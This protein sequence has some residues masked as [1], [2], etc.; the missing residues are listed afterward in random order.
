MSTLVERGSVVVGIDGSSHSELALAWAVHQAETERRPLAIVHAAGA[1]PITSVGSP[2]AESRRQLR[3][4]GRRITD[5][6]LG[7]VVKRSPDLRVNVVMKL[8][9]PQSLLLEASESASVVVLGSRGRGALTSLLLG[10][11]S[12]AVSASARCPVVVV[13]QSADQGPGRI[14]VGIDGSE[15]SLGA[16]GFAFGQ[17][18]LRD[19]PLTVLLVEWAPM[20][21]LSEAGGLLTDT[22]GAEAESRLLISETLAGFKEKYPDV[23]VSVEVKRGEPAPVL[24][25]ESMRASMIVVGS[26][27]RGNARALLMGS[28]SRSVVEHAHCTVAV[29]R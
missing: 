12:V 29:A 21:G 26:R 24:V 25:R 17:A 28:T 7:Y 3:I 19:R 23:D 16:V 20:D 15:T 2:V 8:G 13:R 4:V 10:S 27:G 22:D 9:D 11:V 18:S 1:V 6:A 14:V 5:H